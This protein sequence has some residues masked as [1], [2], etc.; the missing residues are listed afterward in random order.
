MF[1]AGIHLDVGHLDFTEGMRLFDDSHA[2]LRDTVLQVPPFMDP[3]EWIFNNI[4]LEKGESTRPGKMRLTGYQ[5]PVARKFLEEGVSEITVLKGA[6]VGW[7]RFMSGM[8]AYGL[9]YLG[10]S[11]TIAQPTDDDAQSFYNEVIKPLFDKVKAL[12]DL[13]RTPARGDVQ[14]RWNEHYLTNGAV[15]RIVSAASDDSFR[16][17]GS[18]WNFGDEYSAKGWAATKGSQG[19]KADLFAERGGEWLDSILALGST[20]LGV[21][22]CR[23]YKC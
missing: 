21:D 2:D 6:R 23:T 1:H 8:V 11:V 7:S 15:L 13:K 12:R 4:E 14:D 9:A 19:E 3:A 18:K 10:I 17:Y 5:L 22:D 20:P 16:R